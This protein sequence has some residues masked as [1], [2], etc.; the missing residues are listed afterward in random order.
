[1]DNVKKE[2]EKLYKKFKI[3]EE[4]EDEAEGVVVSPNMDVY[5]LMLD[6]QYLTHNTIAHEVFHVAKRITEHR[7]ITDEESQAWLAGHVT[8]ELYKFLD[9]KKLIVKH[10]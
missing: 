2:V 1:V 7:G 10:G 3:K 4:F 8:G 5:Y 6:R 9:K